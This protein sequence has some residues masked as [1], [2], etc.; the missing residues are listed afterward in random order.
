MITADSIVIRRARDEDARALVVLA[1]LDSAA[2]TG[3][4]T[5]IAEVDGRAVAA[6]DMADGRIIADPFARTADLVDLLRRRAGRMRGDNDRRRI[7]TFPRRRASA[8]GTD[9]RAHRPAPVG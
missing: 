7:R 5:L 1:A 4:D 3:A 2:Q 6:L 9:R 8:G